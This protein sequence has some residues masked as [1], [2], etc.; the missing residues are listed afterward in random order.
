MVSTQ[1]LKRGTVFVQCG[2]CEAWH[3]L[4]DNLDLI[5]EYDLK[6]EREAEAGQEDEGK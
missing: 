1:G 4:V 3:Q 2:H 6:A 5:V